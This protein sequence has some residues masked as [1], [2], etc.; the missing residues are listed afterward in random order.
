MRQLHLALSLASAL[1]VGFAS[2]PEAQADTRPSTVQTTWQAMGKTYCL[3]PVASP[4]VCDVHFLRPK[5]VVTLLG[6]TW[7]FGE[8]PGV[9]CDATIPQS[10]PPQP[11]SVLARWLREFGNHLAKAR[12]AHASN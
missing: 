3:G 12:G 6:K 9:V 4:A 7:C 1:V 8:A 5:N 11:E 2:I 10:T